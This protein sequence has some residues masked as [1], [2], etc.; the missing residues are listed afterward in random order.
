MSLRFI[1]DVQRYEASSLTICSKEECGTYFDYFIFILI[2]WQLSILTHLNLSSCSGEAAGWNRLR[3][4]GGGCATWSHRGVGCGAEAAPQ[5]FSPPSLVKKLQACQWPLPCLE[6][7][8]PGAHYTNE[9]KR[10]K[11]S[12]PV[13]YSQEPMGA[14]AGGQRRRETGKQQLPEWQREITAGS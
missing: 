1:F 5:A 4:E 11:W 12:G 13:G 10:Q 9:G 14:W 6:L 3:R 8:P 7:Q 2:K